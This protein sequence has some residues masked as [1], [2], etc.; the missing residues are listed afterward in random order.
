MPCVQDCAQ[1]AVGESSKLRRSGL[2]SPLEWVYLPGQGSRSQLGRHLELAQDGLDV[3]AH[4]GDGH[5]EH[6]SDPICRM[7]THQHRQDFRLAWREPGQP[8]DIAKE[9][10]HGGDGRAMIGRNVVGGQ[11]PV[12]LPQ[13]GIEGLVRIDQVHALGQRDQQSVP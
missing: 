2:G 3:G 1:S 4:G 13:L 11:G 9:M 5:H 6:V 10:L 8:L 7:P 12:D